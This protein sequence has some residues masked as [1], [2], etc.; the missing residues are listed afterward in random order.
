MLARGFTIELSLSIGLPLNHV[1]CL[2]LFPNNQELS[3]P[4]MKLVVLR[5]D[6]VCASALMD[7]ASF[8]SGSL[9]KEEE[10][11]RLIHRVILSFSFASIVTKCLLSSDFNFSHPLEVGD[12]AYFGCILGYFC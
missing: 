6:A 11:T 9:K 3:R 12:N 8:D 7:L 10:K 4:L 2:E 5:L 1:I